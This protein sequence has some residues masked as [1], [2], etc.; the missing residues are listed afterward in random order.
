MSFTF[1]CLFALFTVVCAL[2]MI[3]C[4]NPVGSALARLGSFIGLA[5]LF[6]QINAYLLGILQILVHTGEHINK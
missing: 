6:I 4:E 2:T 5:A 3:F 1:F